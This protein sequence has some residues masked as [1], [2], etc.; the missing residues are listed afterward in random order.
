MEFGC[1]PRRDS[2][3]LR[4]VD[5]FSK[6]QYSLASKLIIGVRAFNLSSEKDVDGLA[7]LYAEAGW[8]ETTACLINAE[9]VKVV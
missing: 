1:F 7:D 4:E 9:R 2:N 3:L 6:S 5:G 8:F